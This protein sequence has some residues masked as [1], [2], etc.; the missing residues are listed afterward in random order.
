MHKA[1]NNLTTSIIE[2]PKC[3]VA[4]RQ[5][6]NTQWF[7]IFTRNW[8]VPVYFLCTFKAN[9]SVVLSPRTIIYFRQ[10][11][12]KYKSSFRPLYGNQRQNGSPACYFVPQETGEEGESDSKWNARCLWRRLPF[13]TRNLQLAWSIQGRKRVHRI[14]T[15]LWPAHGWIREGKCRASQGSDQGDSRLT[16]S[17]LEETLGIRHS[18]IHRILVELSDSQDLWPDGCGNC[19]PRSR[20]KQ[21]KMSA[22]TSTSGTSAST[23]K[24]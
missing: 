20:R 16:V 18:T 17:D 4:M 12:P 22:R 24:C 15:P 7:P 13:Q 21:W 6:N 5:N 19:S 1:W 8:R 2:Y 10:M 9:N 11:R 23:S 3:V 14:C